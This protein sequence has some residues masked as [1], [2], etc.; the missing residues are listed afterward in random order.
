MAD[1]AE[2]MHAVT[3]PVFLISGSGLLIGTMSNRYSR[4]IDRVQHRLDLYS[5]A[6]DKPQRDYLEWEVR[7]L[8]ARARNLRATMIAGLTS[9]F[10][11]VV[12]MFLVLAKMMY[13]TQVGYSPEG[14]FA[15]AL[16]AVLVSLALLIKD[17]TISLRTLKSQ[18]HRGLGKNP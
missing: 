7:E 8:Y 3:A 9:V 10:F 13:G 18:V 12:S 2:L 16:I 4:V 5:R 14:F 1:T 15:A 6:S 17:L 11:V